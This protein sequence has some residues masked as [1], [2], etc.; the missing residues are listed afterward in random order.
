MAGYD[1]LIPRS[2]QSHDMLMGGD[3]LMVTSNDLVYICISR[4]PDQ[5][6]YKSMPRACVSW[7][8]FSLRCMLCLT[9]RAGENTQSLGLSTGSSRCSH[10]V[11]VLWARNVGQDHHAM[12]ALVSASRA[13]RNGTLSSGM[14]VN[15]WVSR[16]GCKPLYSNDVLGV[17]CTS[18]L[19]HTHFSP[20]LT[21]ADPDLALTASTYIS[22]PY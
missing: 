1:P 3:S 9:I 17:C 8:F 21:S 5:Q 15:T 7:T 22:L 10:R 19:T 6:A 12:L 18:P 11:A 13:T 4:R 20:S 2:L 16:F 14:T